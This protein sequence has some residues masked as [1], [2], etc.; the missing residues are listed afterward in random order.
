MRIKIDGPTLVFEF[1]GNVKSKAKNLPYVAA[2]WF[3]FGITRIAVK[4]STNPD[5]VYLGRALMMLETAIGKNAVGD[6]HFSD[7]GCDVFIAS[8]N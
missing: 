1:E 4:C 7:A 2:A 3:D 5:A 6:V 8:P